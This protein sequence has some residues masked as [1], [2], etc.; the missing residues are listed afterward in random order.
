MTTWITTSA[1]E[2][3]EYLIIFL[4]YKQISI[5]CIEK[6]QTQMCINWIDFL[7]HNKKK[8]HSKNQLNRSGRRGIK[9]DVNDKIQSVPMATI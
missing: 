1:R 7:I 6:D 9:D 4:I 2:I 8:L 3:Q 5:L